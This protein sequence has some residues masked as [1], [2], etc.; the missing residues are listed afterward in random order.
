MGQGYP[1]PPGWYPDVTAVG[2][3]RWWDGYQWTSHRRPAQPMAVSPPEGI[4]RPKDY[5]VWTILTT[6]GCCLPIGAIGIYFSVQVGTKW[7]RGDIAGAQESSRT[8]RTLAIVSAA[9]GIVI[10]VAYLVFVVAVLGTTSMKP[11]VPS[12]TY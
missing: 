10:L 3:E 6:I 1:T 11:D 8:A 2:T 5:L 12:G 9:T 4:T 7:D